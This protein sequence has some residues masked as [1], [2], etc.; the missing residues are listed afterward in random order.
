MEQTAAQTEDG[1]SIQEAGM[2]Q[3]DDIVGSVMK[4]LRDNGLENNTCCTLG[5]R[6]AMFHVIAGIRFRGCGHARGS[7]TLYGH[8]N[9]TERGD[10]RLPFV[11]SSPALP[12]RN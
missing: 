2:A 1:W 12:D 9:E 6:C 3:L 5:R 11:K 10:R 8:E 7:A 4:Y